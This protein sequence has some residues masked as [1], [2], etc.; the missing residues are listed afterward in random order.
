MCEACCASSGQLVGLHERQL[1]QQRVTIY[2]GL[3]S[4]PSR[5]LTLTR[6]LLAFCGS[7]DSTLKSRQAVRCSKPTVLSCA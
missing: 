6:R 1:L 4:V 5:L 7:P 3:R 2:L